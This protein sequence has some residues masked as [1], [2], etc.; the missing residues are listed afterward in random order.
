MNQ[1]FH[2]SDF[3][4]AESVAG[5]AGGHGVYRYYSELFSFNRCIAGI[6]G[7]WRSTK[8]L[9]FRYLRAEYWHLYYG[10]DF[11]HRYDENGKAHGHRPFAV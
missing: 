5:L 1:S 9:C 11:F 3:Q 8:H 2:Q 10:P 7:K 6:G 4:A